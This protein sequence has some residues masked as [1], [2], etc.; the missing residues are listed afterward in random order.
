M[1]FQVDGWRRR[2]RTAL[3]PLLAVC[4][5][6]VAACC[7]G[8]SQA[9]V[10]SLR[11]PSARDLRT[12]RAAYIAADIPEHK[13]LED[14]G[15][16]PLMV[17][18][19]KGNA[20]LVR[21]LVE[22][23]NDVNSQDDYG[24]TPIRYAVRNNQAATALALV[25]L[26]ADVDKP[27]K[28]GRTPLMSAA[29]NGLEEMCRGLINCGADVQATDNNGLTAWQHARFRKASLRELVRPRVMVKKEGRYR[30]VLPK[31][32]FPK[33]TKEKEKTGLFARVRAWWRRLTGS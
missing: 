25:E 7:V 5:A 23:G 3:A 26:G 11:G 10:A 29:G 18:A 9:F 24:W 12:K 6:L 1:A 28:T 32:S 27:S 31:G 30:F 4:I 33:A 19:W 14:A 21:A 8:F 17:A 20:T 16:S 2:R 15:A 13:I 22:A